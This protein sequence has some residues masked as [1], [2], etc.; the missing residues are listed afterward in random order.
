M[1]RLSST[2]GIKSDLREKMIGVTDF[3]NSPAQPLG[4]SI[5]NYKM[6]HL[7]CLT[8]NTTAREYSCQWTSKTSY[9][10]GSSETDISAWERYGVK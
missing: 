8:N 7:D 2:E 4:L 6:F 5:M 10:T 3:G 1:T 9:F